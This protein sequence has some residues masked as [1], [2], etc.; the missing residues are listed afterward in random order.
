ML[1][2]LLCDFI[3]RLAGQRKVSQPECHLFARNA[4]TL[5]WWDIFWW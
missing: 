5:R 3:E 1:L 2:I 4:T